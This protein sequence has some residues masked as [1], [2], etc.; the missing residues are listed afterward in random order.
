[1]A[2]PFYYSRIE[3]CADTKKR[4]RGGGI[5]VDWVQRIWITELL[6]KPTEMSRSSL[7]FVRPP[8]LERLVPCTKKPCDIAL[9]KYSI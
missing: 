9:S 2:L 7:G 3:D 4:D 8:A 1:V 6:R 5:I